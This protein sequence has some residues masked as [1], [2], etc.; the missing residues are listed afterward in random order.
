MLRKDLVNVNL[1][2]MI[3]WLI[4]SRRNWDRL[5]EPFTQVSVIRAR[6]ECLLVEFQSVQVLHS[7]LPP[8]MTRTAWWLSNFAHYK[9]NFDG[10]VFDELGAAGLGV[11][12]RD[13]YGCVIG[14][15]S[16]FAMPISAA[17]VEALAC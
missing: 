3:I 10:A 7:R 9:I 16:E 1:P 17:T 5:G 6:A 2:A 13:S 8:D 15:L 12:M 14:A 11:V 4:W